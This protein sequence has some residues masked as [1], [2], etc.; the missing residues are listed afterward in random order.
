ME[1]AE[2]AEVV[3]AETAVLNQCRGHRRCWT[4]DYQCGSA[5]ILGLARSLSW[6]PSK[7][8]GYMN[9]CDRCD[10]LMIS[11]YELVSLHTYFNIVIIVV[12]QSELS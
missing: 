9:R 12:S 3:G 8:R 6:F 10:Q 11:E 7:L 5:S 4:I 2:V 1:T